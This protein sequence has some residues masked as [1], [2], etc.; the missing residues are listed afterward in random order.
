[1]NSLGN[2]RQLA[3]NKLILLYIIDKLEIPVSNLQITKII[4]ENKIM[5]YFLLQ[6]YLDELRES[7]FLSSEQFEGKTLYRITDNGKQTLNYFTNLIPAS[8][9]AVID[10]AIPSAKSNIRN[11]LLVTAD[12]IPESENEITVSCK[13]REDKFSLIDLS[14]AVGTKSDARTICENW[15]KYSQQIYAEIIESL[16]RKR[17]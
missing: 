17:D 10:D 3:E 6:Q 8:I 14:I 4:L 12:Y 11:E 16:T 13:V 1:M 2:N 9:R 15:K 5:N 7:N